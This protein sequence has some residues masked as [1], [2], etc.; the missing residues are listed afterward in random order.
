[1]EDDSQGQKMQIF[2]RLYKLKHYF[3]PLHPDFWTYHLL[4][5]KAPSVEEN[6]VDLIKKLKLM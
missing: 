4:N 5:G 6:Y 3:H 1:V 2:G